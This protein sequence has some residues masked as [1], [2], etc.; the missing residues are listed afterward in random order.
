MEVI[1]HA[2]F[3]AENGMII[4][5]KSHAEC[6]LIAKNIGLEMSKNPLDQGFFTSK[7]RY[8]TRSDA[9][10][11]AI[12]AGQVRSGI[13]ILFSE[14]LWSPQYEGQFKYDYVK[15]YFCDPLT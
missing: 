1:K 2:A 11:V 14:D 13:E 6:F 9:A 8:V 10:F 5:G 4:I 15:G 7:G 12:E 3:K